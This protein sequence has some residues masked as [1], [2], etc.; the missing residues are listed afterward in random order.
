M[1]PVVAGWGE[2]TQQHRLL[3]VL[4]ISSADLVESFEVPPV[5]RTVLHKY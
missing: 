1:M 4:R 2:N 5:A 3:H